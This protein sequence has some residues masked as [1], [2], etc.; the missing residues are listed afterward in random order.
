LNNKYPKV[1]E[2]IAN[3]SMRVLKY[4]KG[5]IMGNSIVEEK[6]GIIRKGILVKNV[7]IIVFVDCIKMLFSRLEL[8]QYGKFISTESPLKAIYYLHDIRL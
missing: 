7:G 4:N 8:V 5:E 3:N 6:I 1:K 2:I